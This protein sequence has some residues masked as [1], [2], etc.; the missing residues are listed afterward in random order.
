MVCVTRIASPQ[1][2]RS[3][4][5]RAAL[6][7]AAWRLLEERGAAATT[8]A[9]VAAAA[10]VSRRGL[11]LH[12]ASRGELFVAVRDHVD[13]RLDLAGS[14]RPVFEAVDAVATLDAWARHVVTYHS[15]IAAIMRAVD[16]IRD[17]DADAAALWSRA[18]TAWH[19]ACERVAGALAA[20][21]RLAEPWTVATAADLLCAF[22]SVEF[23]LE[24]G[25]ERGWGA[26]GLTERLQLVVRRVLVVEP[27]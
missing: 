20:E 2:R 3:Q 17:D 26:E 13:E 5:T 19:E 4:D 6:L 22:M 1:N 15:Q 18:R 21:G 9:A 24:L 10:G 16:R 27:V 7:D 12:F 23:V 11:Y 14:L 25:E 8:M